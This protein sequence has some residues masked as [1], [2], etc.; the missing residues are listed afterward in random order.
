M[1]DLYYWTT[2][3]GHKAAIFCEEANIPYRINP[4]N[5]TKGDQMKEEFFKISPNN[6]IPAIIDHDVKGGGSISLFE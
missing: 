2:P 3:N 6:K 4:V 5:I 1:I